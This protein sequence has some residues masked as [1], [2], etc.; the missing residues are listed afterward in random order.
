MAEINELVNVY[1]TFSQRYSTDIGFVMGDYNYG[2][3]YVPSNQQD[4]LNI[5]QPPFVR[6]IN[7]TD[8]MVRQLSHSFHPLKIQVNRT[9]EFM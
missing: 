4:N 2:G 9:T 3:S 1:N 8:A 7:R 6:F 5:D